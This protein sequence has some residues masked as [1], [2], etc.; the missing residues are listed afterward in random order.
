MRSSDLLS[1]IFAAGV[2]ATPILDAR[3]LPDEVADQMHHHMDFHHKGQDNT[4]AGQMMGELDKLYQESSGRQDPGWTPPPS[5]P[6]GQ[7]QKQPPEQPQ[8][9]HEEHPDQPHIVTAHAQAENVVYVTHTYTEIAGQGTPAPQ[10]PP[11]PVVHEE[12]HQK[13]PKPPP[14]PS[15]TEKPPTTYDSQPAPKPAAPAHKHKHKPQ[16]AAN[17]PAT[18]AKPSTDSLPTTFVEGLSTESA[19]FKGLA[20][21]HHNIHRTNHTVRP[22]TWNHTLY[23]YA[24]TTAESCIYGHSLSVFEPCHFWFQISC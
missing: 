1:A 13:A 6:Q 20:A 5:Q 2:M 22:M 17:K 8:K 10:T 24:K 19:V 9:H 23:E 12:H 16:P 15:A 3:H 4:P 11:K 18:P 14:V 21:L 7:P